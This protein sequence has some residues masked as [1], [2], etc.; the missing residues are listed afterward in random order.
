M[1]SESAHAAPP[2]VVIFDLGGVLADVSGVSAMRTLAGLDTDDELWQRWL[3]CPWVRRF[4]RGG[5]SPE[6]FAAGMVEEWALRISPDNYLDR[7]RDWLGLPFPGAEALVEATAAQIT[8]G[9]LSNTNPVHWNHHISTWPLM[10]HFEHRFL[11]YELGLLKPD[12]DVFDHVAA[13][14]GVTAERIFF[15]DDNALNVDAATDAGWHAHH[16]RGVE[17]ARRALVAA[18]IL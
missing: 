5:C 3:T 4:E 15:L 12:R 17:Q 14:M 9:C 8:A 18:G 6:E 13:Q 2:E 7:F 10:G 16:V 11:S 1:R